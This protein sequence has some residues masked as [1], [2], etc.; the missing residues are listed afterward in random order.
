MSPPPGRPKGEYRS[1][2]HEGTPVGEPRSVWI[3]GDLSG[4]PD[5]ASGANHLVWWGNIA[6]MLIE[7]T[8]FALAVAIYLYLAMQ[9]PAWPPAGQR[10]PDLP[11]SAVFTLGLLLSMLPNLW[12]LHRARA[13]D[14]RGVRI[15][16]LAMTIVGAIL[17]V[18][19]G[20]ELAHLNAP[21][22]DNGYGSVLWLLMV[23]HTS[24]IVTDLGETAVQAVWLWTHQVGDDEFADVGDNAN[25]WTFVVL[26]WLPLFAVIHGLPRWL[27]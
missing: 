26:T 1:A 9:A 15:G 22:Y 12:V 8:G 10:P 21:W 11:W 19:R 23:L 6:F 20:F 24:H 16:S 27:R 18:P 4:L 17:L 14:T 3:V 5:S 7:G 25:Y 2:R 13:K